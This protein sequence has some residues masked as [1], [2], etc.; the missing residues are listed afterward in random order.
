MKAVNQ[1]GWMGHSLKFSPLFCIPS[2]QVPPNADTG[3]AHI[4]TLEK[5]DH[6]V[7]EL[8]A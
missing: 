1:A 3:K 5:H 7:T 2:T 8:Y 4:E 6:G